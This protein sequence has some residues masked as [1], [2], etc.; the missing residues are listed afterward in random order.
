MTLDDLELRN[1]RYFEFEFSML[2]ISE[3]AKLVVISLVWY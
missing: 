2:T 1:G 3:L